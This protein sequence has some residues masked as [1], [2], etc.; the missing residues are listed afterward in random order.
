VKREGIRNADGRRLRCRDTALVS[1]LV[2][3]SAD[4]GSQSI[5]HV[6]VG[7]RKVKPIRVEV[8]ATPLFHLGVLRIVPVAM[9]A[10]NRA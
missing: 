3:T 8:A 10:K 6:L 2:E 1:G 9:I 7:E 4:I 5:L